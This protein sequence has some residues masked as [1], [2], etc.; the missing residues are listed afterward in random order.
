[1]AQAQGC[2]Q[3]H[4]GTR[5]GLCACVQHYPVSQQGFRRWMRGRV[6]HEREAQALRFCW[7]ACFALADENIFAQG[8]Q[9][10]QVHSSCSLLQHW[11]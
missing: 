6:W 1:M 2:M 5:S 4:P 11:F 3:L 7:N 9:Q 10:I 8:C